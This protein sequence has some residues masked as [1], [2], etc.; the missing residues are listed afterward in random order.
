MRIHPTRLATCSLTIGLLA[1]GDDP[2]SPEDQSRPCTDDT[3]TVAVTVTSAQAPT[4]EW[5]PACSVAM[6][7][8]EEDASDTW[9]VGTDE[10]LWDDPSQA[11]LIGPP[12]TYGV[13]PAGSSAFQEP[14]PLVSG[15]TYELI[16][17]R[18]LPPTSTATCM[19]RFDN[20]CLMAVHAFVQ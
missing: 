20:L 7:L 2:A 5:D 15:V 19:Q 10:N 11:N 9:G 12:V 14:L 6:L 8:V 17:W 16:L 18:V 4:F 1:C 13:V 3:G